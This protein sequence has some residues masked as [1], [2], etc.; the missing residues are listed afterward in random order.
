MTTALRSGRGVTI[1]EVRAIDV[2]PHSHMLAT[3]FRTTIDRATGGHECLANGPWNFDW[4]R[5]YSYDGPI[6]QLPLLS[7]GDLV[8]VD[9]HW[10]NTFSN[11]NLPRLLHDA[12]LV[13]PYDLLLGPKTMDEMCIAN[14]GV[15]VANPH[16]TAPGQ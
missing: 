7:D 3:R 10:N 16:P 6:E 12:N 5:T 1:P 8:T 11:P 4:Q 15:A 14:L 13:A 2:T 9:C